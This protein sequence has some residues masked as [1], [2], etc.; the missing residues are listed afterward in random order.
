MSLTVWI[1]I[2]IFAQLYSFSPFEK[3]L[4][5]SRQKQYT[6]IVMRL[7]S[8]GNSSGNIKKRDK[9]KSIMMCYLNN[10]KYKERGKGEKSK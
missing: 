7:D 3:F 6:Y 4:E 8:S 9:E 5:V 10:G 2:K 1:W